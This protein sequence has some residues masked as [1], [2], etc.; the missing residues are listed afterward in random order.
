MAERL[1]AAVL[2]TVEGSPPPRVRIPAS[3]PVIMRF[4][5]IRILLVDDHELIRSGVRS[6]LKEMAGIAIVGEA[7]SGEEGVKL[8][9]EL[10]P[11]I[12]L[13]DVMMP[14]IGGL[15]ATRKLKQA[16]PNIRVIALTA[17][18]EEPFP[19]RMLQ[20]GA[21]GFLTK[22]SGFEE[23]KLAIQKVHSGQKHISPE[24]AQ[25][26]ALRKLNDGDKTP[27][28]GLSDREMQVTLMIIH[29]QSV[30]Q[31]SE[32]LCLSSKTINTYR[33]RIFDKLKVNNDVELTHLAIRYNVL[34][35]DIGRIES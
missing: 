29:G 26:L 18:D 12:V 15:E 34:D 5:L 4:S 9:R 10:K 22:G 24:V 20:A 3:P 16:E 14:G 6:L 21:E 13:M 31:I 8:A 11:D 7:A 19:Y 33:Y 1:K 35:K 2:K 27:F 23:V 17:C 28:D 32:R 30:Q 25:E